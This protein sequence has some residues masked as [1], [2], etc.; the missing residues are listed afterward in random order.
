MMLRELQVLH[1]DQ[2]V[3]QLPEALVHAAADGRAFVI[4]TCQR[5]VVVSCGRESRDALRPLLEAATEVHEG[6][7]AYAFLLRLACGLESRLPGETEVLGQLKQCWVAFEASRPLL[8]QQLRPFM[9]S[10]FRDVKDVRS[11][12]LSGLGSASY[13][14]LV[15]RLLDA[16]GAPGPVLLIGAGQLAESVAPWL[17]GSE[18][19]LANRSEQRAQQLAGRLRQRNPDRPVRVIESGAEAELAAWRTARDVVVCV[20]GD[21][22]LDVARTQAWRAP[23]AQRGQLIHLG[24]DDSGDASDWAGA[25]A[26][27]NLS[28]LYALMQQHD[29]LRRAQL[30]RAERACTERSLLRALG[31]S[32]SEPHGWEDLVGIHSLVS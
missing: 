1:A 12:F 24:I 17:R 18:L 14:S 26:M 9:Q 21:A 6:P 7:R 29:E 13:G 30:A 31:H 11:R 27:L 4:H 15:R 10:L 16:P 25:P 20:P 2:A 19:W 23:R 3:A 32:D 8:A 5:L 28:A 22:A